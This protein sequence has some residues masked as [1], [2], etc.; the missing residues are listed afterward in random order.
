MNPGADHL[1]FILVLLK[2]I[3]EMMVMTFK[4][5]S[6]NRII[7]SDKFCIFFIGFQIMGVQNL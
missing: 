4:L 1:Y 6:T 7:L 2:K 5:Q 3:I